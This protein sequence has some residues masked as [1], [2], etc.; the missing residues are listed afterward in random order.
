[1]VEELLGLGPA[2]ASALHRQLP[3]RRV[4]FVV[5]ADLAHTHQAC[6]YPAYDVITRRV[7]TTRGSPSGRL[8]SRH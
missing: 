2:L 1:M 6:P 3:H 7:P 5:S 4:L 8:C